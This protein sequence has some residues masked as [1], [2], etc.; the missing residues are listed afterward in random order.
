MHHI[1]VRKG[2][3]CLVDRRFPS[4]IYLK[5]R[6]LSESTLI[7][8]L[9][10]KHSTEPSEYAGNDNFWQ[11]LQPPPASVCFSSAIH[12]P[13]RTVGT[14]RLNQWVLKIVP[15]LSLLRRQ[16]SRFPGVLAPPPPIII[17][18]RPG[19]VSLSVYLE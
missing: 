15:M 6:R 4:A 11:P 19:Y 13:T 7:A 9:A 16:L 18:L 17:C 5:T 14:L 1:A 12:H 10:P 8:P 2:A 3:W